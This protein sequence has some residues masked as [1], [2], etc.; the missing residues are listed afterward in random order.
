[1]S[2]ALQLLQAR[3]EALEAELE[4]AERTVSI[5]PPP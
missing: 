2:T 3:K 5:P 1:M 4:K